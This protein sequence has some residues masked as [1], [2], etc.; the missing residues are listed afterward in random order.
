MTN[1]WNW[2]SC[3]PLRIETPI[4]KKHERAL[5]GFPNRT[6]LHKIRDS[7][8]EWHMSKV[9]RLW[10]RNRGPLIFD[11]PAGEQTF[12]LVLR[13]N[14]I[15]SYSH[16][17]YLSQVLEVIPKEKF[18]ISTHDRSE[19]LKFFHLCHVEKAEMWRNFRFFYMTDVEK[20]KISPH[21]IYFHVCL[22][23]KCQIFPNLS[24]I[25]IEI[26]P[27]GRKFWSK[28]LGQIC[29]ISSQ[30]KTGRS[31]KLQKKIIQS[32]RGMLP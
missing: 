32:G 22:V 15:S 25:E 24:Y 26:A 5:L 28:S 13:F 9:T 23:E 3:M 7:S 30:N 27:H 17:W 10:R 14:H 31:Q 2:I 11:H 6:Y 12:C 21:H 29:N 20:S 16:S 18:Q 4:Q 8:L 19:K 1:L